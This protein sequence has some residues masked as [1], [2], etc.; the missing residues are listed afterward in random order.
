VFAETINYH[1]GNLRLGLWTAVF[2]L[3][4][5]YYKVVNLL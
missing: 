1:M 2:N 5:V 3:I 4:W